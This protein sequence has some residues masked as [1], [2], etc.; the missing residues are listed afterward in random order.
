[1]LA[2]HVQDAEE[3]LR[4]MNEPAIPG[5]ELKEEKSAEGAFTI[6]KMNTMIF[7]MS[8]HAHGKDQDAQDLMR[9]KSGRLRSSKTIMANRQNEEKTDEYLFQLQRH[10]YRFLLTGHND[11]RIKRMRSRQTQW[12]KYEFL[13]EDCVMDEQRLQLWLPLSEDQKLVSM[14]RSDCVGDAASAEGPRR[15]GDH[16]APAYDGD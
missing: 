12:D 11:D 6:E 10:F 14:A 5:E 9:T 15:D 2:I 13:L 16:D 7:H 4:S 3:D 8:N 1:M